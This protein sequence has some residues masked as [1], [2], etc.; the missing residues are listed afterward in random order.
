MHPDEAMTNIVDIQAG[1]EH[2]VVLT[3]DG[4]V[5]LGQQCL[6]AVKVPKMENVGFIF[7]DLIKLCS[8]R[9]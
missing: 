1:Y 5:C 7:V 2:A 3:N 6:A 4:K 9:R 8:H